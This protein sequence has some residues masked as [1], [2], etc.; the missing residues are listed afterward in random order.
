MFVKNPEYFITIAN[1]R[2]ISKS[3]EKLYLSQP[4]LSQYLAKLEA[5]LGVTLLDCSHTP[6][7]LMPAGELFLAY[8]ESQRYLDRQ[9]EDDLRQLQDH[10]QQTLHIGVATWRGSILLPDLL[11]AFSQRCPD[12]KVVLHELPAPQLGELVADNVTDLCFMQTP[13]DATGL[14]YELVMQERILLAANRAH[15]LVQG[16]G[17]SLE[18]LRPFDLHLLDQERLIMLPPDWRMGRILCNTFDIHNLKPEQTVETTNLTTAA[19]LVSEGMGFTFLPES[20]ARRLDRGR[21]LCFFTVDDPPLTC[22][23]AAVY[24]KSGFLSPAARALIDL[25]KQT[26]SW[27]NYAPGPSHSA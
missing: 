14:T 8:L 17:G 7:R 26:Y 11:P 24:K 4:Y 15:P 19:N 5:N 2:S 27:C 12:V 23:L 18:D 16:R 22:D 3:A 9:L 25:A 13:T 21:Q 1:E 6:L 10:R 20:G